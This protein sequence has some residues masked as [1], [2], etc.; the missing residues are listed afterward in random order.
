MQRT[1][2]ALAEAAAEA[3]VGAAEARLLAMFELE[4]GAVGG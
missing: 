2:S 1:R 3:R 4:E